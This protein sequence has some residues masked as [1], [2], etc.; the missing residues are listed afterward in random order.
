MGRELELAAFARCQAESASGRPWVVAVAGEAGIGKSALVRHALGMRQ[1]WLHVCWAYCDR[2]EQDYPYGAL[3]QLLRRLPPDTQGVRELS[4]ALIATASPF[5]IG[6]DLLAVLAAAAGPI[7]LVID[8]IT[9]ADP[10]SMQTLAFVKRRLHNEPI[11][12]ATTA[13]TPVPPGWKN[14]LARGTERVL[15]LTLAGL[16]GPE[17][18]DLATRCGAPA[19]SKAA[20]ARLLDRT[21]GHP[22]HLRSLFTQ[23]TVDQLADLSNP[24]PVPSSLDAVIRRSLE[25]LPDDAR[26]LVEALAV[27]DTSAPLAVTASLAGIDD[28]ANALGPALN[29]GIVQ[30]QPDDPTT[31][32]RIHHQLQR[33]AVYQAIT[34]ARRQNLHATAATLVGHDAAWGH[35][36]AS[37]S[38]KNP[39]LAAQLAQEAERQATLARPG[40]A[41]TLLLWAADLAS[42]RR[43]NESHLL[44]A[45][46]HL[47]KNLSYSRLWTYHSA[48]QQ[49]RPSCRRDTVLGAIAYEQGDLANAEQFLTHAM[50]TAQ[51]EDSAEVLQAA[52]WLGRIY[53]WQ[54]NGQHAVPLLRHAVERMPAAT[55]HR[56]PTVL[57]NAMAMADS[58]AAGLT[59][60]A[61]TQLPDDPAAVASS[62]GSVLIY[63]GNLHLT[64]GH[65]RASADDLNT[66]IGQ[67]QTDS[68][69]PR[70][71][72]MWWSLA[73]CD[74]LCGRWSQGMAN[75]E[76]SLV[77]AE[78]DNRAMLAAGHAVTA[79]I[80][81]NRGDWKNAQTHLAHCQH[82]AAPYPVF[83]F[84]PGLVRT[85]IAQAR[86]DQQAEIQAARAL[87]APPTGFG[88]WSLYRVL[89]LPPQISILTSHQHART[90]DD[91]CRAETALD[92]FDEIAQPVDGKP[93]PALAL[94][95]HWLHARLAAA[96]EDFPSARD[97][98][99]QAI[100]TPVTVGDDIPLHRACAQQ[101]YANLLLTQGNTGAA[102]S[103]LQQAHERY[104][105]L[106]AAPFAARVATDLAAA[107][108][109]TGGPTTNG[110][111]SASTAVR[112][113]N[114]EDS[115]AR[116]AMRGMTNQEIAH[117]LYISPKTVEYHLGK[118]YEKL[119]IHSRRQ[120]RT[121]LTRAQ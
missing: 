93:P 87:T 47:V 109:M 92:Q 42:D 67:A 120:L 52:A 115:V 36:V 81:A 60:F 113:T 15:D 43:E 98:Y 72:M 99:Q 38:T 12:L 33:E 14:T 121:T 8:D 23:V 116:L 77:A 108:A 28:A 17:A 3:E 118:V 7:A 54:G 104:N 50:E 64:A 58:P 45:A 101:E 26:R 5:A 20:V 74:Y 21:G 84:F 55:T 2:A 85:V 107:G 80:H 11:L 24:I 110:L 25:R 22:L 88:G 37:T 44:S 31:T 103:L 4:H 69:V 35:K 30:W 9:W 82:H 32:L 57:A 105:Q 106:G 117:E 18:G 51:D 71:S 90:L 27:L 91:L 48:I 114:R 56:A 13:R 79:M 89:I 75:A 59:I 119:D 97:R 40:R 66:R 83:Q 61:E 100:D 41:A 102:I 46:T 76:L 1:D 16:T 112:L 73:L 39:A 62:D 96:Q 78:T 53:V 10:Q 6:D 29:S 65:L 111:N 19:L 34:P 86:A 63:R 70:E 49:C 68:E 94:T 95:T